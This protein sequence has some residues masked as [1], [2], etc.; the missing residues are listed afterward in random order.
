MRTARRFI[1]GLAF[2]GVFLYLAL[3]DIEWSDFLASLLSARFE[4]LIPAVALS[5]FG[6]YLR[7]YRWKFMLSPL[8]R[9]RPNRLFSV[10]MIGFMANNLLPAR[11]GEVLRAYTLGRM[12]GISNT[13]AFATIVYE[14]I[15]D[16]FA[17]LVLL[18]FTLIRQTGLGWL[19]VGGLWILCLNVA[20]LI[21]LFYMERN[22]ARTETMLEK[23]AGRLPAAFREKALATAG[24]F[25]E[26]LK[27]IG[28][29]KSG[30][31]VALFSVPVWLAALLAIH[32]CLGAMDLQVPYLTS[33]VLIV[34]IS[35]GS[36]IPSAPAYI[37]TTQYACILGLSLVGVGKSQALAFSI[38]YHATQFFPV[39]ILGL[40][41]LWKHHIGFG[42]M[43]RD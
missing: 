9:I 10:L 26:G 19:R 28:K 24:S 8:K 11:L 23:L 38:L 7:A 21:L 41:F 22:R 18:W 36:M 33:V 12:E 3:R 40:V 6:H 25:L 20:L 15:V 39:T 13:G 5:L 31:M 37:G 29:A 34:L 35:L 27:I 4:Y 14:R 16:V 32:F 30:A 1:I 43:S 42:V 17:L 2:S